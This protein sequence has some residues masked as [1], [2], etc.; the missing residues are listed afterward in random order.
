ML[1]KKLKASLDNINKK[2][3]SRDKIVFVAINQLSPSFL[4]CIGEKA[5]R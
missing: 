2:I 1:K 5:K 3:E 4:R